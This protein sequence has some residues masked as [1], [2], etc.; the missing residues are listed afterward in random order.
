MTVKISR[1]ER[2]YRATI[3][4]IRRRYNVDRFD[5]V[6]GATKDEVLAAWE[7]MGRPATHADWRDMVRLR[8]QA[9]QAER[10]RGEV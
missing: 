4:A 1:Q 3:T 8:R 9:T 6:G 10:V 5:R 7:E 2:A